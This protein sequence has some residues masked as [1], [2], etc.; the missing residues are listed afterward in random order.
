VSSDCTRN[1]S[2]NDSHAVIVVG[3]LLACTFVSTG[4][5]DTARTSTTRS[6]G[7]GVGTGRSTSEN[8][9]ARV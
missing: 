7:P 4:L 1:R 9:P 3:S 5:T 8:G 6:R 2:N